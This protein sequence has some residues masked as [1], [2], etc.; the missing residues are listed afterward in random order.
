MTEAHWDVHAS[1]CSAYLGQH[2]QDGCE[3][4]AFWNKVERD[5][6]LHNGLVVAVDEV[7]VKKGELC[8]RVAAMGM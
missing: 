4:G 6:V 3:V 2:R 7:A 1:T 5:K 8:T